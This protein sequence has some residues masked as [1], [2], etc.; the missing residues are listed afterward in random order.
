M[1]EVDAV[2]VHAVV[3]RRIPY[4]VHW[5]ALEEGDEDTCHAKAESDT[6]HGVDAAPRPFVDGERRIE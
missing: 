4:L 3:V 2:P 1:V 6:V 5:R